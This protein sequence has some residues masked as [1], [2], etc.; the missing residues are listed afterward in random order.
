MCILFPFAPQSSLSIIHLVN[1][2]F[3]LLILVFPFQSYS[4]QSRCPHTILPLLTIQPYRFPGIEYGRQD[5][6]E[7]Q[8]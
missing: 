4:K 3:V 6:Y 7:Q 1:P 8:L 2:L 5:M